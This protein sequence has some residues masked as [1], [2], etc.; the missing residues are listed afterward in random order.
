MSGGLSILTMKEL[1]FKPGH[2]D[3]SV[4]GQRMVEECVLSTHDGLRRLRIQVSVPVENS[5]PASG[6]PVIF[7]LDGNAVFDRFCHS[8][9]SQVHPGAGGATGGASSTTLNAQAG[10]VDLSSLLVVGIGYDTTVTTV[11]DGRAYDYTPQIPGVADLRDPR[12]PARRAGGAD[13]FIQTL[14]QVIWP[15][16]KTR[17]PVRDNASVLYGHSYGGLCVLH[18]LF[19]QPSLFARWI[20]VSPSL[21]WHDRYLLREASEFVQQNASAFRNFQTHI[22]LMA[23]TQEQLRQKPIGV[24]SI[25][26]ANRPQGIP[27]LPWVRDLAGQLGCMNGLNAQFIELPGAD[28]RGALHMS[29]PRALSLVRQWF[30]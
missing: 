11:A 12:V 24:D 13:V 10:V 17:Y 20:A 21:W 14:V 25:T 9:A 22:A 27:T 16:I 4:Y 18:T 5:I 19:R 23:G 1:D 8:G 15:A 7:M 29:I 6:L 3:C 26:E 30:L 28:H 2:I